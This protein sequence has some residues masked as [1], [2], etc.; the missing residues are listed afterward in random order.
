MDEYQKLNGD[1]LQNIDIN[2]LPKRKQNFFIN[3]SVSNGVGVME[4]SVLVESKEFCSELRELL[5]KTHLK[6]KDLKMVGKTK[7]IQHI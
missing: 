7:T 6:I 1:I 3:S 5:S 4:E 2:T